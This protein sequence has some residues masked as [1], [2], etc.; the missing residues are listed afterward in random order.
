LNSQSRTTP[1]QRCSRARAIG[2]TAALLA[3]VAVLKGFDPDR[4]QQVV[5]NLLSNAVEFIPHQ[6]TIDL[7]MRRTGGDADIVVGD[8][9]I[10][11][12]SELVPDGFERF[13][14]LPFWE[15]GSW[16]LGVETKPS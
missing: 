16:E 10:G 8:T 6:G 7:T 12:H 1:F 3:A 13:V 4:V 5:W 14:R 9:G 2:F 11:I 15:L